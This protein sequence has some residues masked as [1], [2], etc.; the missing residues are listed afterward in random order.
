MVFS[1]LIFFG[2]FLL[3]AF[4]L[5]KAGDGIVLKYEERKER[6]AA[7]FRLLRE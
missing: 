4:F 3:L 1:L 2:Y 6:G 7:W 5:Y